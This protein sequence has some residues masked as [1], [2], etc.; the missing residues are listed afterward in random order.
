VGTCKGVQG[1]GNSE[2]WDT[3]RDSLPSPQL[4]GEGAKGG[5]RG[6]G[7]GAIPRMRIGAP[8]GHMQGSARGRE[9]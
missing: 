8:G 3:L 7:E 4:H 9:L 2:L 1:D 5:A 6:V